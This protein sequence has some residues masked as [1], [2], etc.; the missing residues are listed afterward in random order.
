MLSLIVDELEA[1]EAAAELD[2]KEPEEVLTWAIDRFGKELAICCSFQAD[3]CAL[4]DMAHKID[5][6]IRVFTIDTGRMPQ[7]TYDLVDKYRERYGIKV[8]IFTPDT[9]VVEQMA[10]RHGNNLFY[11]DVN[12]RLLCCHTQGAAAAPRADEL[13]RLGDRT[14]PR[15]VGDALEHQQN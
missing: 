4:I 2:D 13:Q 7:E 11:K 14:A 1:G 9:V 6:S 3:G 10:T 12:L 5:P 15:S 8:E